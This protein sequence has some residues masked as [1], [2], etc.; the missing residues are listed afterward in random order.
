MKHDTNLGRQST[1][2]IFHSKQ[3]KYT[4][5]RINHPSQ[6]LIHIYYLDATQVRLYITSIT[7]FAFQWKEGELLFVPHHA[8]FIV[9]SM[10]VISMWWN[11]CLL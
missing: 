3:I 6:C 2:T 9:S 4:D 11:S 8:F 5:H 7:W 1:W 10:P